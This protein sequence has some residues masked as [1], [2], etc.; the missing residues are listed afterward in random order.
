[1]CVCG[2]I[3]DSA[4]EFVVIVLRSKLSY[5]HILSIAY[6]RESFLLS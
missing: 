5:V 3:C 2:E 4:C 1:M 6:R